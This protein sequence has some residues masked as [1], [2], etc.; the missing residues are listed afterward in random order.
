MEFIFEGMESP[1][2]LNYPLLLF[3]IL[4]QLAHPQE[5][6]KRT[7][8]YYIPKAFMD[9][10]PFTFFTKERPPMQGGASCGGSTFKMKT[11]IASVT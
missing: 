8:L 6:V 9:N 1:R 3:Q 7:V 5:V 4:L 11:F 2:K 10:F